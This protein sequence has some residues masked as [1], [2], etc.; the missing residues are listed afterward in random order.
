MSAP[1]YLVGVQENRVQ[2]VRQ[3]PVRGAAA[4][5]DDQADIFAAGHAGMIR[6]GGTN[7]EL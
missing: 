1:R 2:L 7:G 6:K 5:A 4:M 3:V